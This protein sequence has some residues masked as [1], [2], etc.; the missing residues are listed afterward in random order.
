MEP[1]EVVVGGAGGASFG[2]PRLSSDVVALKEIDWVGVK[3]HGCAFK[4]ME[5]AAQHCD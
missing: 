3:A 2:E 4:A 5:V 1:C